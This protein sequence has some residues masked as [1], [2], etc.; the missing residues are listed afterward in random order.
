MKERVKMNK[1]VFVI[2]A[3]LF[4]SMFAFA[5]ESSRAYKGAYN[6]GYAYAYTYAFEKA[7]AGSD[8]VDLEMEETTSMVSEKAPYIFLS[9]I[10]L[11]YFD[12]GSDGVGRLVTNEVLQDVFTGYWIGFFNRMT[13]IQNVRIFG[14]YQ[15]YVN[16]FFQR[17]QSSI[18][19]GY[20]D[21]VIA[22]FLEN[23]KDFDYSLSVMDEMRQIRT[24]WSTVK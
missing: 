5:D 23:M 7:V 15:T 13:A 18:L 20:K 10:K 24:D 9:Y 11:M 4:V 3:V 14:N 2:I 6:Q 22:E 17:I 12:G 1:R 16:L 19:Y 21:T 8:T